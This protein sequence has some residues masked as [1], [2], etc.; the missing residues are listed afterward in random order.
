MKQPSK[1]RWL[2]VGCVALGV[3]LCLP[4]LALADNFSFTG[5]FAADD[6]V[7]LFNFTVGASS[8]V[9]MITKSYA[10]G[11]LAD[12]TVISA[13]GFD[14]ILSL[15]DSTG[16]LIGANDDGSFDVGIDPVTG[17]RFDTFL[18]LVLATGDY[19][20]AVSQFNNFVIGTNLSN[21]FQQTGD[22]TFTSSFG[23]SNGQFCDVTGDNRTNAW[24]FDVLNVNSAST[25]GGPAIPE[26]STILLFGSGLAGLIGW[27]LR[28]TNQ[29]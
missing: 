4:G 1:K 16:S 2:W 15:F 5:T 28:K 12:G 24:A 7:Q 6:D 13:G 18:Q 11:T 22:P 17:R 25:P 21:G 23:C 27:R 9:T 29:S 14:P 10:G 26:P 20:V 19:M 8:T 3:L